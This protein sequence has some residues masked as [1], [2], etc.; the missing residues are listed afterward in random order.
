MGNAYRSVLAGGGA[1][2]PITPSNISPANMEQGET[3]TPTA[4][5]KAV[6]SVTDIIPSNS[7]P[8]ALSAGNI[9]MPGYSGYAIGSYTNVTPT[10]S[11]AYFSSGMKK[12][13]SSGYAYS[14]QPAIALGVAPNHYRSSGGLQGTMPFSA[15]FGAGGASVMVGTKGYNTLTTNRPGYT[16]I[17]GIS[18]SGNIVSLLSPGSQKSVNVT[19]YDYAWVLFSND[20]SLVTHTLTLS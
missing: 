18:S 19:N 14:S 12:M 20:G 9:Y 1:G 11:G 13:S 5:G 15:K 8:P 17:N 6:E 2:T 7:N 16:Y 10:T 4:N 3:Y